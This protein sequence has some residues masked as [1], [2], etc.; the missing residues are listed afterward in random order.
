MRTKLTSELESEPLVSWYQTKNF[1]LTSFILKRY[2]YTHFI[3]TQNWIIRVDLTL[4]SNWKLIE[5]KRL[6][7]PKSTKETSTEKLQINFIREIEEHHPRSRKWKRIEK[8]KKRSRS[9]SKSVNWPNSR[10]SEVVV[11]L[12]KIA[13]KM[14]CF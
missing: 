5:K 3:P 7:T 13:M 11:K 10:N 4:E 6:S 14:T 8:F 2:W 9:S 12:R 1:H